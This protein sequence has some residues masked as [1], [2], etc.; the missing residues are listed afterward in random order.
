MLQNQVTYANTMQSNF[1][2]EIIHFKTNAEFHEVKRQQTD[3]SHTKLFT[4]VHMAKLQQLKIEAEK[5]KRMLTAK[6]LEGVV[7][8]N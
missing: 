3:Q 5:L 4:N 1:L 8:V 6:A 7:G 2:S